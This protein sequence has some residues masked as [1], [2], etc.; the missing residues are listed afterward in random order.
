MTESLLGKYGAFI[1]PAYLLTIFAFV[2]LTVM[3]GRR[4]RYWS[5]RAKRL[6]AG[7]EPE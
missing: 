3:I 6:E 1:V 7:K 5:S 4:L 2:G